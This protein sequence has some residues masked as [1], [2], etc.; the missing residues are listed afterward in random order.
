M[1][2]SGSPE[3]SIV[4]YLKGVN[5]KNPGLFGKHRQKLIRDCKSGQVLK[6]TREH[7]N[8]VDENAITV[9]NW[10]KQPLGYLSRHVASKVAPLLD[11]GKT[12]EVEVRKIR[13]I[14]S[15]YDCLVEITAENI[16]W[17]KNGNP[18]DMSKP[19]DLGLKEIGFVDAICPYCSSALEKKPSRKKKCPDCGNFIYVR[20]RP[21]DRERVLVTE[22]QT[23]EIDRQWEIMSG[24]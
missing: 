23:A 6:L 20:T 9:C 12:V 16:V 8:P 4:T 18:M 10:K 22:E 15:H 1:V 21:I 14:G 2:Y 5:R 24:R 17:D 3:S 11:S 7:N 13:D 19:S